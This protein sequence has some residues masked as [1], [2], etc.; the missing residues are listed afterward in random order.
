[1]QDLTSNLLSCLNQEHVKEVLIAHIKR[2][3]GWSISSI[4]FLSDVMTIKV[5]DRQDNG[6]GV[7]ESESILLSVNLSNGCESVGRIG[8][9]GLALVDLEI[10]KNAIS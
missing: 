10:I 5:I 6:Y 1:M 3:S 2:A 9:H 4:D 7:R 8:Q